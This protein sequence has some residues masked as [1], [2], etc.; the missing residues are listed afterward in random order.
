MSI[1]EERSLIPGDSEGLLGGPTWDKGFGMVC[2]RTS[3]GGG[4]AGN[5]DD[6]AASR[7]LGARACL[8]WL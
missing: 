6:V 5:A 7:E 2:S 3:G 4:G 1:Y 8:L